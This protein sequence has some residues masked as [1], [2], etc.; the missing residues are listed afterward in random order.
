TAAENAK[1]GIKRFLEQ[2]QV[3]ELIK[4]KSECS[5]VRSKRL[6]TMSHPE[7][8]GGS[9]ECQNEMQLRDDDENAAQGK[10]GSFLGYF[11]CGVGICCC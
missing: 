10:D 4:G 5:H 11:V 6:K 9:N 8:A 1:R 2:S 7:I 3:T